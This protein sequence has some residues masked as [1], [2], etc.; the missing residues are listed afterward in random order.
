[1]NLFAHSRHIQMQGMLIGLAYATQTIAR[2]IL[3]IILLVLGVTFEPL[4][5][6]G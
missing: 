4:S 2:T 1:M 5:H 6:S 3:M